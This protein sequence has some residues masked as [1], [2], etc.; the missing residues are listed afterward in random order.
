MN[1]VE[2]PVARRSRLARFSL[3][4]LAIVLFV[5]GALI[6]ILA[7]MPDFE[8]EQTGI[9]IPLEVPGAAVFALAIYV[10][11]R[12]GRRSRGEDHD[13]EAHLPFT[14]DVHDDLDRIHDREEDYF[15]SSDAPGDDSSG[16]ESD[17]SN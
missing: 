2:K 6:F 10:L 14:R 4:V 1:S 7:G 12:A 3:T 13:P 17:G 16:D 9:P 11:F 5:A 15:G 8:P